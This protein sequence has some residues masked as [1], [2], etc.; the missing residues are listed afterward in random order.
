V[1]RIVP[2]SEVFS[3]VKPMQTINHRSG[4]RYDGCR[5]QAA[6]FASQSYI[7]RSPLAFC[8]SSVFICA[9]CGQHCDSI[10]PSRTCNNQKQPTRSYCDARN[11]I[12]RAGIYDMLTPKITRLRRATWQSVNNAPPQL[13]CIFLL[14]FLFYCDS[15]TRYL[16]TPW[17]S[18][19]FTRNFVRAER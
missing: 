18:T 11:A 13:G 8:D 10:K 9:I 1:S 12:Q 4:P 7:V 16:Q 17:S 15:A 5:R 19:F 14:A 2:G 6:K 3:H